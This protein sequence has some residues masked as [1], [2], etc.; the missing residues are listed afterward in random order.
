MASIREVL[1]F[2]IEGDPK[3]AIKAF[4]D[5]EKASK[6]SLASRRPASTSGAAR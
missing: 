1:Q 4:D 3:G 5:V 6:D 2:V